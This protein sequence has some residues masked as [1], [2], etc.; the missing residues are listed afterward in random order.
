MRYK[1]KK[2]ENMSPL[3]KQQPVN[4]LQAKLNLITMKASL[5]KTSN[6]AIELNPNNPRHVE[7]FE[8]DKY[9]EQ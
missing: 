2:G 8:V 9:K 1:R 6:G 4:S 3:L 5:L 7:W